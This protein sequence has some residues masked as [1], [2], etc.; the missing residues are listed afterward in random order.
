MLVIERDSKISEREN[1][2]KE[3]APPLKLSGL[4]VQELQVCKYAN[5]KRPVQSQADKGKTQCRFNQNV[6]IVF[7]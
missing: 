4:S 5:K 7:Y 3:R 1:T 2:L 6:S